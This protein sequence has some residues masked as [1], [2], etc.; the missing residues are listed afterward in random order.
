MPLS[1]HTATDRGDPRVGDAAFRLDVKHVPPSVFVNKDYQVRQA[2]ADLILSGV[3]E[4]FPRLRVGSGR[5]RARRG[6]RS[7]STRWTTRTRE[8][9]PRGDWYRFREPGVLPSD[10]FRRNCFASFQEDA[11]RYPRARRHRRRHAHVGQRLPAHRVDVPAL[12]GDPRRHPR[13]A[14]APD[15]DA[16]RSCRPTPPSL[17][18]FDLPA[19]AGHG[20]GVSMTDELA[21]RGGT[22]VDGT[23]APGVRAD[24][25]I[26][27]G[28]IVEIGD[29]VHRAR[30]RSTPR[31][32]SS[33][34]A[35]STSTPT[36]TRRCCGIPGSRRRRATASPSVVAGNCGYSLAPTRPAD[37][38]VA[39]PHPRQGRG[40][41]PRDARSRRRLG[42]RDLPR[43]PRRGAPARHRDQLRRLRRPHR[44]CACTSW[45]TTPTSARRPTTRSTA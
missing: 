33:C 1:L 32:A 34:P 16:A 39:V 14:C 38:G 7:S 15:D 20:G 36:T 24:V 9:P 42:L 30:A 37:R 2:L 43:V 5:A 45:A 21:I 31:A 26:A 18:H 27:D 6:S 10:Y 19:A 22:V 13:R 12:A 28:R 29:R 3:F 44:R 40:H 41:A 23:G 17:Y 25:G 8:R 35:S 11:R 4:R